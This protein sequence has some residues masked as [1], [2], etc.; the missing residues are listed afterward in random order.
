MPLTATVKVSEGLLNELSPFISLHS[1]P[2]CIFVCSVGSE[3]FKIRC[4]PDSL[5]MACVPTLSVCETSQR[6]R[7][8]KKGLILEVCKLSPVL[9]L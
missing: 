8:S 9:S 4:N 1:G 5:F 2:F 7:C 3:G 6:Q